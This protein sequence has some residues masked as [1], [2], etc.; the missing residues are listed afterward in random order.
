MVQTETAVMHA[1]QD[2]IVARDS[3]DLPSQSH[4]Y[5]AL[6][7]ANVSICSDKPHDS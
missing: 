7:Y 5:E 1:G 6:T 2:K 3:G 4:D